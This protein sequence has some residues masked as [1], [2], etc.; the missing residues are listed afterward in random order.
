M[1]SALVATLKNTQLS[2]CSKY[3]L[4]ICNLCAQHDTIAELKKCHIVTC[5]CVNAIRTILQFT[6]V[7]H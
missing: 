5:V 4:G 3:T 1:N 7:T 2:F 6:L